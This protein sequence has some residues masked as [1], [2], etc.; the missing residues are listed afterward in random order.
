MSDDAGALRV[1]FGEPDRLRRLP[2]YPLAGLAEAKARRISSGGDVFD[3]G[4]GDP[5]IAIPEAAARALADAVRDPS[6]QKY[7]FQQGL[8]RFRTAVADFMR[9][10]YG[11]SLDPAT[12]ILP[13]IG[14]KEGLA[15]LALA[16]LDP[17]DAAIV[18]DPGYAPY[19]GGAHFAG[20]EI[21]R[22]PLRAETGFVVPPEE[23]ASAPGRVRLI[24][25]NY[26][27]N[28]TAA[29]VER[30]YIER[31][32]GVARARGA[33]LAWDNAYAE[34]AFDG[35]RPPS[36]VEADGGLEAGLEFHS[37]SKTFNMTGWRLG[38]ACGSAP[39]IAM[40][41]RVKTFLDTGPYLALQHAGAAVLDEAESYIDGN[42]AE[43]ERRR[44]AAVAALRSVGL[45]VP[46]PRAT[47]YLWFRVPTGEPTREFSLRLIEETGVVLLPGSGLGEA[48][49]G[50][51]RAA[52]TLPAEAYAEVAARIGRAL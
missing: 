19:F 30:D 7:G 46:S 1:A 49:E 21:V 52:L 23:L 44:D 36:L 41:A 16:A 5:G 29:C 51:V 14:S 26:P 27:N 38:W 8:P 48:G 42:L 18:P 28:P 43:L 34:V 4:A 47:L 40:L 6:L 10:R 15:H 22:V 31:V 12:E 50:F 9:R 2:P 11:R 32:A 25:L 13:L 45:D 17:G 33:L 20:A 3:L 24:Y 35:Y 37:F 39:L